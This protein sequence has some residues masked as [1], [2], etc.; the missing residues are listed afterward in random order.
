LAERVVEACVELIFRLGPFG[1]GKESLVAVLRGIGR[2]KQRSQACRQRIDTVGGGGGKDVGWQA[3][4]GVASDRDAA[5]SVGIARVVVECLTRVENLSYVS[6][7][8]VAVERDLTG[9][10]AIRIEGHGWRARE[11][12]REIS[13]NL[14]LRGHRGQLWQSLADAQALVVAEKE[15]SC[16]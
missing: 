4:G 5:K 15:T 7:V 9:R 1:V 8:A 11:D 2:G 10:V 16:S 13:A 12:P 3:A 6:R 14:I